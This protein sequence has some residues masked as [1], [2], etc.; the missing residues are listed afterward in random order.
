MSDQRYIYHPGFIRPLALV[1]E[2]LGLWYS[3]VWNYFLVNHL[4]SIPPSQAAEQ[5][6]GAI[7]AG[8]QIANQL[9]TN[10]QVFSGDFIQVRF[11]PLDDIQIQVFQPQGSALHNLSNLVPTIDAFTILDDPE[12]VTT[13]TYIYELG[14]QILIPR[15]TITNPTQYALTRSV[16]AFMGHRFGL[17]PDPTLPPGHEATRD[18]SK[19]SAGR[20]VTFVP[21]SG[22]A[23]G[24]L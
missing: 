24:E 22:F 7:A 15:L 4:T 11:W 5:D 9:F 8:A 23:G 14:N 2:T 6:F 13:E 21:V 16:V 19:L 10:I 20:K 17:K 18:T 12:L 1:G 3:G